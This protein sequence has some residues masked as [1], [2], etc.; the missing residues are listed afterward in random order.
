MNLDIPLAKNMT[1]LAEKAQEAKLNKKQ[2]EEQLHKQSLDIH[3]ERIIEHLINTIKK[4]ANQG[5]F[6]TKYHFPEHLQ[7]VTRATFFRLTAQDVRYMLPQIAKVFKEKG[8][9]VLEYGYPNNEIV[10]EWF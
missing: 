8:Y 4:E 6:T 2:Q 1:N 5:A 9:R 10:V 7:L 3:V